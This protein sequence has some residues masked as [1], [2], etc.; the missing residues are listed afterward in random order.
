MSFNIPFV[1]PKTERPDVTPPA[2]KPQPKKKHYVLDTCVL[3]HDPNSIT[4]FDEHNVYLPLVVIEELDKFKKE[5]NEKGRNA[6]TVTRLIDELRLQGPLTAGVQLPGGGRFTVLTSYYAPFEIKINDDKILASAHY[7]SES[8]KT[9]GQETILVSNDINMRVRANIYGMAVEPFGKKKIDKE[10]LHTGMKELRVQSQDYAT[11]KQNKTLDLTKI[12]AYVDSRVVEQF[13]ANDY[14]KLVHGE[15]D[16]KFT[17]GV[18]V[19]TTNSIQK[20]RERNDEVFGIIP[21]N[22][23]QACAL[24]ALM[25]P[26]INLVTLIGKAGSGKT[27]IAI[28]A[29]LQATLEHKMYDK[30][31]IARPVQPMGKDIGYLPGTLEEKLAPWMQPIFDN[32]EFL[33]YNKKKHS[34]QYESVKKV[35]QKIRPGR[36]PNPKRGEQEKPEAGAAPKKDYDFL[37]EN[38]TIKVEALTY[39]R[40]RSIPKQFIIIDE[41]QNLTPHEVKTIITRAGEGTKIVLTGDTEQIDSPY[42]DEVSNGLAYAVERLKDL[43][44]TSHVTL[45][46]CERSALAE[47]GTKYL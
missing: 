21:K 36:T 1:T 5:E 47:A 38:Q 12:G 15:D 2:A 33:F 20:I 8:D 3:L 34:G 45:F 23:E 35:K 13:N 18:Y 41:A 44:I 10:Q 6:R 43:E 30:I 9:R 46:E 7:L 29:A 37:L 42:L 11:F 22:D 14:I 24:D 25:D 4:S 32:L 17:Y 27:L 16:K 31:L 39:I 28:A 19:K 40:G 26:D